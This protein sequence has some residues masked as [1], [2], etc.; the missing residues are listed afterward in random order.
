MILAS[1]SLTKP[2]LAQDCQF[3]L[4]GT[5]SDGEKQILPGATVMIRELGKGV[6]ANEKGNFEF[7][8]LCPGNYTIVASFVGYQQL[9]QTIALNSSQE[10]NPELVEDDL[11]LGDVTV[12]GE[13]QKFDNSA[14]ASTLSHEDL[15]GVQTRTLGEILS[16]V[17]GVSTLQTG[18]TIF[19]PVIHGMH[20]HR[21]MILNNG[22]NIEG[23]Q[24]G[25]EHAPE[26][27]PFIASE[28]SVIK[29]AAAVRYGAD[30]IGGVVV[31]D[32]P[33]IHS[34]ESF[35]G[36]LNLGYMT[37]G[38]VGIT[39][40]TV[41]NGTES[42]LGWRLQ[43]TIKR[44]GDFQTPNYNLTNTGVKEYN[45]TGAIGWEEENKGL[46]LYVSS[47]NS[48]LGILRG[49]HIGNL[50]DL[51]EAIGRTEPFFI[52]DFS[53]D[54]NNPR[55]QVSH[56][57]LKFKAFADAGNLGRVTA[58]YGFQYN[59]RKEFDVRR[60]GRSGLPALSL[61]LI[62][63]SLDVS[64]DHQ[65]DANM[66]GALGISGS[67]KDNE[68]VPGTGIR[69][70][71]PD[72]ERGTIG[73]YLVEKYVTGNW[74]LDAGLRFDHQTLN[75]FTFDAQND[76]IK[77]GFSFN[78][79]SAS[80]GGDLIVSDRVTLSTNIG[81]SVRP[82]HPFELF[83]QGLHTGT[84]S[85]E[86]GLLIDGGQ[87]AAIPSSGNIR[88]EESWKWSSTL[89]VNTNKVHIDLTTYYN[90]IDNFVFLSPKE[91][92]LT[93]RGAFPVF[94]Y[95]QTDAVFT[96]V[97][98]E[99]DMDLTEKL[100]LHSHSSLIWAKD[101][102]RDSYLTF[103]PAQ[104]FDNSLDY[105]LGEVGKF[106]NIEV[107]LSLLNVL[108]QNR[109][110]RVVPIS[111]LETSTSNDV[112]DFIPA[113]EGYNLVNL[114]FGFKVPA[115]KDKELSFRMGIENIFNTSYRDYMNRLKYYADDI[116]R[117]FSFSLKYDFHA[118]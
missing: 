84:G 15:E 42:G 99:F 75:V 17:A 69:P 95:S 109:A 7:T 27:D 118:H 26:I 29:G 52:E 50:T 80:L 65:L 83:S 9:E 16:Q 105:D 113:P 86:E 37:N 61:E 6:V 55:Q 1:S 73:V 22:I 8:G 11:I 60:A 53:Y 82:P 66:V 10:I 74:S 46:E 85:I 89:K 104:T 47:F 63:N 70:I 23:Q 88:S 24:W 94:Q 90:L 12:E 5:I 35:G 57:L 19:K 33:S 36:E 21:L 116:G 39:S 117:N 28:I 111:E 87:V 98:F 58:Q 34:T 41:E 96:G 4:Y 91:T 64:L 79:I 14:I 56:H 62:T 18:P 43:G 108:Q 31:I 76:L 38:S 103:I 67:F 20:S 72:Y 101:Q 115:F 45:F 97:D 25:I 40:L 32:P 51:A 110:P 106:K 78:N 48:E 49:A 59:Q 2:S 100:S 13:R 93:I 77:P 102:T 107:S 81:R 3:R 54:I 30:A 68:N 71:I 92:R 44:G 112:F 114:D